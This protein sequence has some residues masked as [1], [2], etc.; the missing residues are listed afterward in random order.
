MKVFYWEE[1]VEKGVVDVNKMSPIRREFEIAREYNNAAS[2]IQRAWR[3]YLE[4][5]R[6]QRWSTQQAQQS[7]KFFKRIF[8]RI[9]RLYLIWRRKRRF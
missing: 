4:N 3:G 1:F 6:G 8:I 7:S 2:V 9:S 5:K